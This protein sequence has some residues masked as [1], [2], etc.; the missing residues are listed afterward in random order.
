V[1]I[2]ETLNILWKNWTTCVVYDVSGATGGLELDYE[3][4]ACIYWH[5]YWLFY[6]NV[7]PRVYRY[8]NSCAV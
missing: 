4:P 5:S 2:L 8:I 7:R 1:A 3:T 6:V